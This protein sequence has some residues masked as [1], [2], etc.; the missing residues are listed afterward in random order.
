MS[1]SFLYRVATDH[2]VY[3]ATSNGFP[4]GD[5]ASSNGSKTTM[6]AN[7]WNLL[8]EEQNREIGV[9]CV[10]GREFLQGLPPGSHGDHEA[11][12]QP[13]REEDPQANW[14]DSRLNR[15]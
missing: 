12:F 3:A 4:R 13:Q 5:V 10:C 14:L 8:D 1:F 2:P 7:V 15:T 11:D 9:Q 6:L